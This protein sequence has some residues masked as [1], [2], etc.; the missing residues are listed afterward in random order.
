L[1]EPDTPRRQFSRGHPD[2]GK[3]ANTLAATHGAWS[4]RRWRPLAEAIHTARMDNPATPEWLRD[5]P[6]YLPALLDL[7]RWEAATELIFQW[8]A[9]QDLEQALSDV[10]EETEVTSPAG[11]N[12]KLVRRS[13]RLV[14]VLEQY[15][16]Y[17]LVVDGKRAEL[18]LTPLSR[19][20]M[21]MPLTHGGPSLMQMVEAI[22]L[23]DAMEGDADGG[24]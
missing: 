4:E 15:R 11:P 21:G 19:T 12:R 5:D 16:R 6:S 14:A 18:G 24:E 2:F 20:R 23:V 9:D 8:A 10:S 17:T 3:P 1:S 7:A 22:R 13:K